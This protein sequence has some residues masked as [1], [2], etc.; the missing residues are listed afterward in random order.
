M[1]NPPAHSLGDRVQL[2]DE[3]PVVASTG[4]PVA[5]V[6]DC[7]QRRE[8]PKTIGLEVEDLV[9]AIAY[10][11]LAGLGPGLVQAEPKRPRLLSVLNEEGAAWLYPNASRAARLGLAAGLLQIHDFWDTSHD[12]AQKADDLG[13][14]SVSAYWHGIAHRREP[15]AGNAAYWFRRVGV[16]PLF[17]RLAEEV[18]PLLEGEG[19]DTGLMARLLPG[20]TWDPFAFISFCDAGR[21]DSADLARSIQRLEMQLLLEA[22]IPS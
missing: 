17:A 19:I 9:A 7:L 13:E 16:H 20:G 15:D 11:A 10:D 6:L 14:R 5:R 3:V 8:S 21:S 1:V 12:A 22:S 4:I 2:R 18:R